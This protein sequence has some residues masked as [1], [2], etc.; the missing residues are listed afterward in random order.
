MVYTDNY[1]V[2]HFLTWVKQ[3]TTDEANKCT[4]FLL[5]YFSIKQ[6][7]S[8]KAVIH[9]NDP[10][11]TSKLIHIK[12]IHSKRFFIMRTQ[13]SVHRLHASS[14]FS[15][16]T[17][18]FQ[19]GASSISFTSMWRADSMPNFFNISWNMSEAEFNVPFLSLANTETDVWSRLHCQVIVIKSQGSVSPSCSACL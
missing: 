5:T 9:K 15:T 14:P 13:A 3:T 17:Q 16:T 18:A 8:M 10:S 7:L 11:D 1:T 2:T 4:L 12:M 19:E 6:L